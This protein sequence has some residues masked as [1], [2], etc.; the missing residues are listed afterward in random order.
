MNLSFS[1]LMFVV[2]LI[3]TVAGI[4]WLGEVL[5][6]NLVLIPALIRVKPANRIFLLETV[7]PPLFRLAT[8]L[9]GLAIASG[10]G[11]VAWFTK[12]QPGMLFATSWGW[13]ITIGGVLL[14][15][16][17]TFHLVQESRLEES[18]ASNLVAATQ[19]NDTQMM[20]LLLR[21]LAIIPRLGMAV[22]VTGI[23]LMIAAA[24]L[25]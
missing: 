16:L 1:D 14:L 18:L 2:R 20:A 23:V 5:V 13:S 24:H 19:A 21:R 3:H 8:V 15:V 4:S 7:F 22:L 25:R 9:G 11:L 10:A 17:Y 12:L 6:I